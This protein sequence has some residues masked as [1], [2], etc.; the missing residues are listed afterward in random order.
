MRKHPQIINLIFKKYI[1]LKNIFKIRLNQKYKYYLI[2]VNKKQL[3]PSR[4]LKKNSLTN[5]PKK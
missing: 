4:G 5:K 1:Y 3:S 2:I